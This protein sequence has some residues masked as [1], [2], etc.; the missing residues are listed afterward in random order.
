[1]NHGLPPE[2]DETAIYFANY[3][4]ELLY[5]VCVFMAKSRRKLLAYMY[6]FTPRTPRTEDELA[7]LNPKDFSPKVSPKLDDVLSMEDKKSN[8]F[9][10]RNSNDVQFKSLEDIVSSSPKRGSGIKKSMSVSGIFDSPSPPRPLRSTSTS[11][12]SFSRANVDE[13]N[14]LSLIYR[15][16][17]LN[18]AKVLIV[19][20][21]ATQ[22]KD[23]ANANLPQRL[24]SKSLISIVIFPLKSGLFHVRIFK[25]P[26]ILL[27]PLN[28]DMVVNKHILPQLVCQTAINACLV[29]ADSD[30]PKPFAAR[31]DFIE[32][33]SKKCK[34]E[35]SFYR[36]YSPHFF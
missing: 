7:L 32:E 36:F 11:S 2:S 8:S 3:S 6:P 21:E 1:L 22:N 12:S 35:T 27:G 23:H 26:T 28:D 16:R 33:F 10:I 19:W 18:S 5:R 13:N 4:V 29:L 20:S 30:A 15:K 34:Y 24:G 25:K 17:L 14:V 31:K 9:S